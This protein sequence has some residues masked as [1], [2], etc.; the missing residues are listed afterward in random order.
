MCF[1]VKL[2]IDVAKLL[3]KIWR[4]RVGLVDRQRALV[5]VVLSREFSLAIK[6]QVGLMRSRKLFANNIAS[7]WSGR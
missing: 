2:F 4:L 1:N 7:A 3:G 6:V 5:D